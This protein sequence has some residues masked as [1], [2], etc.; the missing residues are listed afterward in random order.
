VGDEVTLQKTREILQMLPLV[1]N[2]DTFSAVDNRE[3]GEGASRTS[4]HGIL[5]HTV[6]ACT[7]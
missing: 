2:V 7:T 3:V 4:E 1:S 6:S 5:P